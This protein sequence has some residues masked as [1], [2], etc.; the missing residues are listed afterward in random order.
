MG[1]EGLVIRAVSQLRMRGPKRYGKIGKIKNQNTYLNTYLN[2]GYREMSLLRI[3]KGVSLSLA[4][5]PN[6]I[7]RSKAK[8]NV[9]YEID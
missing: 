7:Q 3:L 1:E 5:C 9:K 6:F 8:I 2:K 4:R